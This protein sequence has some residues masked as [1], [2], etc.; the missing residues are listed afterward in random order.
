VSLSYCTELAHDIVCVDA[1]YGRPQLVAVYLVRSG[2]RAAFIDT[3]TCH[4]VPRFLAVLDYYGI[5]R[6]NVD[7]V[8]PT[9]VHLDHAGGAGELVRQLPYARLVVHPRGAPHL[10]D[11]SRLIAGTRAVYGE[12]GYRRRFG[13][14]VAVPAERVV[15]AAD[16]FTLALAGR[17]L[18]FVDSP[19]HARH[20]FCVYD[21][22][23][24]G[25]FSGDTFGIS[26]REFD[27]DK[28]PFIF[29]TTTPPQFDPEAWNRTLDRLLAYR[30]Q[31]MYLT[32][33]GCVSDVER[34]A[35]DLRQSIRAFADMVVEEQGSDTE[36][37]ARLQ[38]RMREQLLAALRLH[39]CRLSE[40][41]SAKLLAVDIEL[42]VQGLEVWR[43]RSRG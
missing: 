24:A 36:Q 26:Y 43:N 25:F 18:E 9:H 37:T 21:K 13:Q 34:L 30:P 23:S 12:D 17:Q 29:A 2:S 15:E 10:I 31:R 28:G 8:I 38:E 22:S 19:G 41:R 27:T 20:H 16:G 4:C 42:N 40:E 3:G 5:P 33:F 6:A 14:V 7:Y 1:G 35:R 39:G 32:H 11:P